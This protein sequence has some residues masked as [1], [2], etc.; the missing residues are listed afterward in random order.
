MV[1]YMYVDKTKDYLITDC[2]AV[3]FTQWKL[4]FSDD[5]NDIWIFKSSDGLDV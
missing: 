2:N 1:R 4:L 5:A 3:V